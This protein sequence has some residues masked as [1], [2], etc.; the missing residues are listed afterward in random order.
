PPGQ[1]T[2]AGRRSSADQPGGKNICAFRSTCGVFLKTTILTGVRD[3]ATFDMSSSRRGP[4]TRAFACD[5]LSAEGAKG[6]STPSRPAIMARVRHRIFMRMQAGLRL[7]IHAVE[8]LRCLSLLDL[9]QVQFRMARL[10]GIIQN[11]GAVSGP[12]RMHMRP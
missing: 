11:G 12:H 8:M 2:I 4:R 3:G 7:A 1:K 5:A 9:Q 6:A 10:I